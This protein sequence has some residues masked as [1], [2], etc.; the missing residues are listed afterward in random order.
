MSPTSE[1]LNDDFILGI[2]LCI[3][4]KSPRIEQVR[5]NMHFANFPRMQHLAKLNVGVFT[6]I[7]RQL[8]RK[9]DRI[10]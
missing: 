2:A 5:E 7:M 9:E 4:W 6:L 1:E 10:A 8:V 3:I